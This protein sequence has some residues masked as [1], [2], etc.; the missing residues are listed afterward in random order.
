MLKLSFVARVFTNFEPFNTTTFWRILCLYSVIC[1]E[2]RTRQQAPHGLIVFLLWPP[3]ICSHCEFVIRLN[4]TL[5]SEERLNQ[6][7]FSLAKT[8]EDGLYFN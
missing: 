3:V 6:D 1:S 7:V 4:K 2:N 8:R 5:F